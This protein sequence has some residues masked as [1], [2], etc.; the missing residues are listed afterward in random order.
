MLPS[1]TPLLLIRQPL[2]GF[3]YPPFRQPWCGG[4][5]SLARWDV[6]FSALMDPD[7]LT[8]FGG[9]GLVMGDRKPWWCKTLLSM[10]VRQSMA[11]D[12]G[13]GWQGTIQ[14][15]VDMLVNISAARGRNLCEARRRIPLGCGGVKDRS[16]GISV[17]SER[18]RL[19]SLVQTVESGTDRRE[20]E[21]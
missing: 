21:P 9:G 15:G 12:Q 4:S 3:P 8:K 6:A 19:S 13:V 2:S 17:L 5:G 18:A 10:V 14:A 7:M 20:W 16:T 11:R 1:R